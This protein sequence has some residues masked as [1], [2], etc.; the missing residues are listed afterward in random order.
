MFSIYLHRAFIDELVH[1]R[2]RY[3]W[4]LYINLF[5]SIVLFGFSISSIKSI[6]NFAWQFI[7]MTSRDLLY[8]A[9]LC[10]YTYPKKYAFLSQ[11]ILFSN[12]ILSFFSW[13]SLTYS[14]VAPSGTSRYL[15]FLDHALGGG[16]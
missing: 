7:S 8:S 2:N 1:L 4:L 13:I 5:S 16:E 12:L 3:F 11:Q 6:S 9:R 15:C 10:G 14:S